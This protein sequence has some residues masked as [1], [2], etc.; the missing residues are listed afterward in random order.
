MYKQAQTHALIGSVYG[1]RLRF[2]SSLSLSVEGMINAAEGDSAL[3]GLLQEGFLTVAEDQL[4]A[5]AVESFDLA[6]QTFEQALSAGRSLGGEA[7]RQFI[8]NVT[9]SRLLNLRFGT[10]LLFFR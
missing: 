1:S 3:Q 5:K 9:K 8:L 4:L 7:G 2:E 10:L 6:D